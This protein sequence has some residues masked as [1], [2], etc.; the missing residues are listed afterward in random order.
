M[1]QQP[2][3][4]WAR[5]QNDPRV[6]HTKLEALDDISILDLSYNSFAGSFCTSLLFSQDLHSL[7]HFAQGRGPELPF[8]RKK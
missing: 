1:A 2:L 5:E 8:G 6:A 4:E 3:S 7:W